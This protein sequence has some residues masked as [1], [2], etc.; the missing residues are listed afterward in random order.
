[1]RKPSEE[2]EEQT[3]VSVTKIGSKTVKFINMSRD[4]GPRGPFTYMTSKILIIQRGFFC[5]KRNVFEVKFW[6]FDYFSL[7]Q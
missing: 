6:Y 4:E 7:Q 5:L 3:L 2:T 1:M